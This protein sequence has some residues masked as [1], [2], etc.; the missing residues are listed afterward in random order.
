VAETGEPAL[1]RGED[2]AE[3]INRVL[4]EQAWL[5]GVNLP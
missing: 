3:Q 2:L 1:N 4:R 5:R